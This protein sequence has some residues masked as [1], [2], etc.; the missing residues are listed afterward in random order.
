MNLTFVD[1]L[2]QLYLNISKMNYTNT[3]NY[4]LNKYPLHNLTHQLENID[5]LIL[6][7][8]LIY[9]LG[10]IIGF[11]FGK[12]KNVYSS[13][14]AIMTQ[15]DDSDSDD[16]DDDTDD[17]SDDTD[18]DSDD[19]D[20]DSDDDT[21]DDSDDTDDDSD[22]ETDD[23]DDDDSD[24][25]SDEDDGDSEQYIDD[26]SD[27]ELESIDDSDSESENVIPD[28]PIG[29]SGPF[30]GFYLWREKELKDVLET[31]Y[32]SN[33]DE[34]VNVVNEISDTIL[35]KWPNS[36]LGI[37]KDKV[38]SKYPY[39]IRLGLGGTPIY[40]KNSKSWLYSWVKGNCKIE[41][42]DNVSDSI[43]STNSNSG[44]WIRAVKDVNAIYKFTRLDK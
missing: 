16:T 10:Y 19:T 32:Y 28:A 21:D 38:N 15:T 7:F 23:S 14:T 1:T 8:V 17:D 29:W 3:S 35:S 27:D 18:D 42:T 40:L 5:P 13:K 4:Y 30:Y 33:F 24:D 22:D 12:S 9:V 11:T 41:T 39:R 37:T 25:E 20:D 36:C 31:S 43:T 34:A 26:N 6:Q 44:K 2:N